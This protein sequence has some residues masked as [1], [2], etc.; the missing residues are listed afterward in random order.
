MIE[1]P[2]FH[3]QST[4][5][6]AEG[7]V[8]GDNAVARYDNGN[9]VATVGASHRPD[10]LSIVHPLGNLFVRG[11]LSERNLRYLPKRFFSKLCRSEINGETELLTNAVKVF[12]ELFTFILKGVVVLN[13][14]LFGEHVQN[15]LK[16][17]IISLGRQTDLADAPGCLGNKKSSD[18]GV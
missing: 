2:L 9:G 7:A 14:L 3:R 6:A 12:P 1:E 13:Y 17:S 8:V 18:G 4:A 5:E 10:R 15:P 11:C 16:K